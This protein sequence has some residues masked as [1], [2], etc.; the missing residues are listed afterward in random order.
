MTPG[1]S[2]VVPAIVT[3]SQWKDLGAGKLLI[4]E[5]DEAV[6]VSVRAEGGEVDITSEEIKEDVRTPTLPTRIGVNLKEP[7]TRASITVTIR[8]AAFAGRLD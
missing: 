3:L 7:V 6:E 8:P 1:S 2:S 4:H 5:T